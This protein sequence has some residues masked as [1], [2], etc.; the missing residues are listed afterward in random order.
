[1]HRKLKFDEIFRNRPSVEELKSL[2]RTPIVALIEN[3]RS[4]HNVGSIFRTSD[5][6]RIEQLVLSGFTPVPPRPEISKTAL[7]STETVPWTYT[8]NSVKKINELKQNGYTIY[9]VEQTTESKNYTD[10][11]YKF[12]LCF[13][14]GNEVDG[15]SD[16]LVQ[17]TDYAIELPMLGIKHSLNVSVAYGIIL[18]HILTKYM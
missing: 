1:M 6:A 17:V 3:I 5:G 13:I 18:Y 7:G 15:V 9:T 11:E 16:E 8:K 2:S 10:I 12:P 4:M 14:M